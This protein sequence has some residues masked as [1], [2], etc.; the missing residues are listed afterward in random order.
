MIPPPTSAEIGRGI[1]LEH[2]FYCSSVIQQ[3]KFGCLTL[4]IGSAVAGRMTF[5]NPAA[6]IIEGEVK[7]VLA[8]SLPLFLPPTTLPNTQIIVRPWGE[9]SK[10]VTI[11]S[12]CR[13]KSTFPPTSRRHPA[14]NSPLCH[15][16]QINAEQT[17]N[18][19][20]STV[21]TLEIG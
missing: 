7:S 15:K 21:C 5:T 6:L 2:I 20:Q 19:N 12:E 3:P 9:G 10:K 16:S 8:P 4:I 18:R 17:T 11:Q 1:D 13:E 14:E